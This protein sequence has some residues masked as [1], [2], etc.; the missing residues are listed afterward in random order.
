[1]SIGRTFGAPVPNRSPTPDSQ[2][3]H[4][5]LTVT[6][7]YIEREKEHELNTQSL[8][9]FGLGTEAFKS[10]QEELRQLY[11]KRSPVL[12]WDWATIQQRLA[13]GATGDELKAAVRRYATWSDVSAVTGT[14]YVMF[15]GRFFAAG[16]DAPWRQPFMLSGGKNAEPLTQEQKAQQSIDREAHRLEQPG[17]QE[18]E[19]IDAYSARIRAA[20][21]R[22][23]LEQMAKQKQG[24]A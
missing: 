3:P 10:L 6:R 24:R 4:P 13:E 16:A 7:T 11:P 5:R 8:S 12:S 19:S 9:V 21:I 22:A 1:V 20:V 15:P 17:R 18:K 2:S 14:R 23:A